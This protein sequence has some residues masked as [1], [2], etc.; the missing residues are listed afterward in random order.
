M[1]TGSLPIGDRP[2]WPSL[3]VGPTIVCI[4]PRHTIMSHMTESIAIG[5]DGNLTMLDKF[6]YLYEAEPAGKVGT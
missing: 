5:P 3:H 4:W 2:R 1:L 6:G